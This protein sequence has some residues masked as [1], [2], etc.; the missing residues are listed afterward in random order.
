MSKEIRYA[1]F[2]VLADG[3][4]K[5]RTA[6]DQR[7]ID[8]LIGFGEQVSM[9]FLDRPACSKS[10]AAKQLL[11]QADDR[12]IPEAQALFVKI[13][14]DDNP[15]KAKKKSS[16]VR[17]KRTKSDPVEAYFMA[18]EFSDVKLTPK[19]AAKLRAE[20]N[21]RVKAAYEAN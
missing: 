15:F 2:S 1:G 5:F 6:S 4:F 20:F 12:W 7:R 17:V 18:A 13:A 19:Q 3:T 16:T 11:A 10:E 14:R 9:V 21:A 8:Q